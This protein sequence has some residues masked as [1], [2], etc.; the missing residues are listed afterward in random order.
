MKSRL[1][2]GVMV[3]SAFCAGAAFAGAP[4]KAITATPAEEMKWQPMVPGNDKGPQLAQAWGNGKSG[5]S[6]FFLRIPGGYTSPMHAHT[7]DYHGVM[8]QGTSSH[9]AEGET[10]EKQLPAGSHWTVPAGL[11]HV[12]KCAAGAD[13]LMLVSYTG[14]FDTRM[15]EDKAA[16][17]A[18][19]K[20][21][22]AGKSDMAPG[23]TDAAPGKSDAAPGKTKADAKEAPKK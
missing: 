1:L 8:L 11:P 6:A 21:G 12:N 9:P 13:C 3:V 2:T 18:D 19:A 10:G 4:K 16:K 22:A 23:K 15:I 20:G 17:K 7:A 5:S 14:K